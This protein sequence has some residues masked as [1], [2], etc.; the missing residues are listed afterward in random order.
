MGGVFDVR[1]DQQLLAGLLDLARVGR[2]VGGGLSA[3]LMLAAGLAIASVVRL[4][5]VARRDEVD[6][7]FLVGA[8]LSAI[9]GPFVAEGALQGLAGTGAAL[10]LLA[11][12]HGAVSRRYADAFASLPVP[13]LPGWLIAALLGGGILVGGLT[14]LAAV[15]HQRSDAIE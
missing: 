1:V 14:A 15:R 10:A 12:A 6:V 7:L 13:F 9:R 5:Y 2:L 3:I 11:L 4:S 8:P